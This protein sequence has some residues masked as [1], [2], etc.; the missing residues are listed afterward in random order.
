MVRK[1]PAN[2]GDMRCKFGILG[3]GRAP[4][5]GHDN[6]FEYSCMENPIDRGAWWAIV[7]KV[8]KSQTELNQLSMHARSHD[9]PIH[10]PFTFSLGVVM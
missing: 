2:A 3:S 1:P 9:K 5:G 8:A 7:H 10:K 4:R 6:P